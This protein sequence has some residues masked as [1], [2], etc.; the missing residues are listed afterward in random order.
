MPLSRSERSHPIID[1]LQARY[2]KHRSLKLSG[3]PQ[4][5][6]YFFDKWRE[7]GL[8]KAVGY[9]VEREA[10]D[11]GKPDANPLTKAAANILGSL[12]LLTGVEQWGNISEQE[13][14][15]RPSRRLSIVE[16]V[17]QAS[18]NLTFGLLFFAQ[19]SRGSNEG[20]T[21]SPKQPPPFQRKGEKIPHSWKRDP[22][23]GKWSSGKGR[24]GW[25]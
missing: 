7:E 11:L 12:F 6:P 2:G 20:D 21:K 10:Q 13:L 15:Q 23:S 22:D 8:L 1:G 18:L 3:T 16:R 4:V 9:L 24:R 25:P 14:T 19:D 5:S 17:K